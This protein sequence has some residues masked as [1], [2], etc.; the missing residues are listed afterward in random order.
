LINYNFVKQLK[1]IMMNWYSIFYWV[2]RADSVKTFFDVTSDI[3]TWMTV[4][5]FIAVVVFS[6]IVRDVIAEENLPLEEEKTNPKV[7][8][9]KLMG[10]YFTSIF[11]VSLF[12]SLV[13]WAGY[14]FTPTKKETLLII[15]GG[16]TMQF[17]TTDSAAKQIPHELS[18][19]VVTEL[20]SMAKE[21]QVDLG[22]ATQ[23]DKI[24]EEA[25]AMTSAQ[26]MERIKSDTNFAKII[27]DK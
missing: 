17:L 22:I 27:L 5:G 2:T 12:L 21:A 25:K 3:F 11:Y 19:F 23:K 24:V 20:K 13:T 26:L 4:L 14:V 16:G 18:T 8:S 6:F 9:Y 10:R 15:A 7:R 1:K